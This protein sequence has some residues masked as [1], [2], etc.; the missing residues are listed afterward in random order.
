ME[1]VEKP[2]PGDAQRQ[3]DD[4][5]L[6]GMRAQPREE[7]VAVQRP[8]S[9]HGRV[10]D[11][12]AVNRSASGGRPRQHQE[13][14]AFAMVPSSMPARLTLCSEATSGLRE[15]IPGRPRKGRSHDYRHHRCG[16]HRLRT[17]ACA[18]Q[19]EATISN[20]RGPDSLEALDRELVPSIRAGRREEAALADIVL[21]AVNWTKLPAALAG[22]PHWNG[23]I[24]IDANHATEPALFKP[25][26]LKGRLS[27]EVF[28]DLVPGARV[29]KAFIRQTTNHA[30]SLLNSGEP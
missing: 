21:V 29:V 23:R 1:A 6:G 11:P 9:C 3:F 17:G 25:F 26:D 4:R 27:S 7:G 22:L 12:Q 10:F 13:I 16:R 5:C 15:P 14:L 8:P 24:V 2:T 20:S 19:I 30:R 28:A 18:R